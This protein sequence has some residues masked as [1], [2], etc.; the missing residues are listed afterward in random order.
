MNPYVHHML[1]L[2]LI[3]LLLEKNNHRG[4]RP[5]DGIS[6]G[7]ELSLFCEYFLRFW[8]GKSD[9]Q[10]ACIQKTYI[11]YADYQLSHES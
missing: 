4:Q 7:S 10:I 8:T 9:F 2:R 1:T 11:S 6:F 3:K 5:K